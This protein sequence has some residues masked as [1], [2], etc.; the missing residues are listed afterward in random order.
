MI[1]T[2]EIGTVD[3]NCGKMIIMSQEEM[4]RLC[5]DHGLDPVQV[6]EDY[7]NVPLEFGADNIYG[8]DA[9]KVLNRDG[10]V[11][12]AACIGLQPESF[13]RL[14]YKGEPSFHEY[15]RDKWPNI[16]FGTPEWRIAGKEYH[17][18]ING[19]R[20]GDMRPNAALD[21]IFANG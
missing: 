12:S 4:N 7:E 5:T 17:N 10:Q 19:I 11:Y 2:R 21:D 1:R 14:L 6:L 3:S 16:E 8:V 15:L 20:T 18:L 9:V 13:V